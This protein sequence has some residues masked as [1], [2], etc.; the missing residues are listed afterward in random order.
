MKQGNLHTLIPL[1]DFK[2]ILGIDDREDDLCRFVLTASTY[3]IE[4]YCRRRLIGQKNV[5]HLDFMGDYLFPLK[6]YPVRQIGLVYEINAKNEKHLIGRELYHT[7]PNCKSNEDIPFLLSMNPAARQ[8]LT[9]QFKV[10]Y[11]A[12]YACGKAPADLASACLELAAWNF[13]RYRGRRIGTS[14]AVRGKGAEA[15]HLEQQMPEQV[16]LLLE[17]YRRVLI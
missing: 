2:A 9:V 10:L 12:G 3:T 11:I 4:R 16:K 7:I 13:T 1:T 8:P 14:G 17:P 15:E 5:E 6:E